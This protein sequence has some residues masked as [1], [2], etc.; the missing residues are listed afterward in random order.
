MRKRVVQSRVRTIVR[1]GLATAL[2]AIPE[3]VFEPLR[4]SFPTTSPSTLRYQAERGALGVARYRGIPA[5]VDSFRLVD[6]PAVALVS[7]DSFIVENLYW[8][9]ERNGYEPEVLHWWRHYCRLSV[10]ILELGANIGYFAV[11]GALA[12][13]SA[14][15]VA[16]EPHPGAAGVLRRNLSVN[17]ITSVE[18]VEAAAVESSGRTE[19]ELLLPRGRDHYLEAPCTGFI[20]STE[21]HREDTTGYPSVLVPV[22]AITELH[23]GVDLIKLDIEGQE[24]ALLRAI[25]DYL[26]SALPTLF[27][28]LLDDTPLLRSFLMDLCASAPYQCFV[29]QRDQLIPLP[30]SRLALVSLPLEFGTRDLIMVK[31]PQSR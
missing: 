28:E 14:R 27:V 4:L 18:V 24:A 13:P 30:V 8:F 16:V 29:P 10:H 20:G 22:V 11:Q 3:R 2:R 12:N 15:Y 26:K 21:A 31:D 9:G 19:M 23:D 5:R 1:E 7:A 17:D 25:G 6:N